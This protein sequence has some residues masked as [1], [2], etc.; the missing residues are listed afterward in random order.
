MSLKELDLFR[1][2]AGRPEP[3]FPKG[4]RFTQI[5][6]DLR[7]GFLRHPFTPDPTDFSNSTENLFRPIP[8][9][10]NQVRNCSMNQPGA[11]TV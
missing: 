6:Q 5:L 3:I 9:A 4:F 2:S 1:S 10:F 7:D 8:G 11:G